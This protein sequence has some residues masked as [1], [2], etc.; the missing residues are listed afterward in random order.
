LR[1]AIDASGFADRAA[2][3]L[4]V[5]PPESVDRLVRASSTPTPELF[6]TLIRRWESDLD[7]ADPT[8]SVLNLDMRLSLADDLLIVA[9]HFSMQ[10]SVEL[11]VP[12]L[13]LEF[14][15]LVS[16]MPTRYKISG[17]GHRKWLYREAASTLLPPA[18]AR[19]LSG[20]RASFGRKVGFATPLED[21]FSRD[22]QEPPPKFGWLAEHLDLSTESMASALPASRQRSA[23]HALT[24]WLDGR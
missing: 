3:I 19:R 21:W 13:D 5:V 15:E 14:L 7:P 11:R 4:A 9:D 18:T 6:R 23:F 10:Q 22:S 8:R 2:A 17:F 24:L 16:R 12:F 20:F 1:R